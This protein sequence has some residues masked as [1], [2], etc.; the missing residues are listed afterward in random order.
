MPG[1]IC[2]SRTLVEKSYETQRKY[3][4]G[5]LFSC[6]VTSRWKMMRSAQLD[7][8]KPLLRRCIPSEKIQFLHP[9]SLDKQHLPNY[10]VDS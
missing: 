3:R 4:R 10:G 5:D 8:L 6:H 9:G 7:S 1:D 2:K